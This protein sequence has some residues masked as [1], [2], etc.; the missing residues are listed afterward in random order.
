MP[1]PRD[2][3]ELRESYRR[4]GR[5]IEGPKRDGNSTGRPTESTNLDRWGL[6]EIEPPSK[7][8]T[9]AGHSPSTYVAD[10]QLGLHVG[11]PTTGLSLKLLPV[12]G[13]GSPKWTAFVWP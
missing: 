2:W 6:A 4:V 13:S 9:L 7:M 1:Q 3:T 5:R 10:V 11:P 12:R 8:H